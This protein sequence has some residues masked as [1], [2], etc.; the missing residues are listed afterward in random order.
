MKQVGF[1]TTVPSNFWL[2][3]KDR[4]LLHPDFHISIFPVENP[5]ACR[6][7]YYINYGLQTVINMNYGLQLTIYKQS[8]LHSNL[9]IRTTL[10][11]FL[12]Q[13]N[14]NTHRKDNSSGGN[15]LARNFQCEEEEH[16][17]RKI[18]KIRQDVSEHWKQ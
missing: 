12:E 6:I 16:I 9:D 7:L 4:K 15:Y 5:T 11:H 10:L 13:G 17:P 3:Q 14:N 18:F 1:V 2:Q 8:S